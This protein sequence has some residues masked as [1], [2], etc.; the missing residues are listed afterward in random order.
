MKRVV[1]AMVLVTLF[2]VLLGGIVYADEPPR[3]TEQ[4]SRLSSERVEPPQPVP[5]PEPPECPYQEPSWLDKIL[6]SRWFQFF[7][8]FL[9]PLFLF[10]S[11]CVLF[12]YM[13]HC[14]I[15][16]KAEKAVKRALENKEQGGKESEETES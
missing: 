10:L 9:L 7:A 4:P 6:E 12:G 13:I 5:P 3:P 14:I 16:D 11:L 1:L 2:T 8:L 15:E